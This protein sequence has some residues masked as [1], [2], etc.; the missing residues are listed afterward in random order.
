[1]IV[2]GARKNVN[3]LMITRRLALLVVILILA[4]LL[5]AHAQDE[6]RAVWQVTNFD[7]TVN[8]PGTERAL[9]ARA[10][11]SVRNVGRGSGS[12]LTLRISSKAE[13]KSVSVGGATASYRVTPETR[14]GAQRVT[15]ALLSAVAPNG[16]V[17]ATVDYRLPVEENSG[18]AALSPVGSQF[19]PLSLWYPSP[20]TSLAI[21]GADYAPFRLTVTGASAVSSGAEKS[22]NGNSVFEQT[23]HALPFFV[24]GSW[25]RVDG[26][27]NAKGIS[28][29]LPKGAGAD[30]RKQAERLI[31]LVAD[32]RTFG[33]G[34]FGAAPE[35]PLRLVAVSRGAGF[36]DAGTI[37]L[38]AGAFQRKKIDSITTLG[39]G[40]AV[41]HLW[42]GGATPVRGEGHG[43][44]REALA[45]FI[46]TQFIDQQFGTDAAEGERARQRLAY[47]SIAKRDAPLALMTPLDATYFNSIS[48]K[49]AMVWRLVDHVI[50]R[51]AFVTALRGLLLSG[52]S[53]PEGFNLARARA[54][55]AERGGPAA[56]GLLDAE[57]DHP[58][59]MDLMAGLPHQENGQWV[60]ALRN[61]GSNEVTVSVTATTDSGQQVT[62]LAT[63]PAHDFAQAVFKTASRVVR[64]EVDP[65]KLYPQLDYENDIAPRQVEI[66]GSLAEATRLFGAQ[67]FAKADALARNLIAAAPRMQEA[68][69]LF[70]RIL[71]AE[72]KTDEAEREF[73]KLADDR[74]PTPATLAWSAIGLGEIALRRGQATEAARD[75]NEAARADAEYSSTV[76]ARA[77]RIRAEVTAP[78]AIDESAKA[79]INQLDA[80]IRSGRQAEIAALIVPGEL[81]KFVRGAVGTQPE[82]WQTRVLRSEQLDA[83]HLALD[84]AL[85]TKQ[86][87]VEHSGT[88][89]YILARVGGSWKLNAIEYFEVR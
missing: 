29:F 7:I 84:V 62:L 47:E 65:E 34:L 13:I 73:R 87:G 41:A 80:A 51:D 68:R 43:V 57:F 35:V 77:A 32:A 1:M 3:H 86:L 71:L 30:E 24:V 78:P 28:A 2:P 23:L 88:A 55:F 39:I 40:E 11:V 26:S 22:A 20:N 53:D 18:V 17:A 10:I 38:G 6:P 76:A 60:A 37:L 63:I 72:N 33:A 66:S 31:A 9:N 50:G 45:R 16:T 4:A 58:T 15:I 14:G 64:V 8:N 46:A 75:F 25:D 19:L 12:S 36:D 21:H 48:N 79:F 67:E 70:A 54:V 42:I 56:K 85:N 61:L 59:D 89:V 83:N 44:V 27:G 74:L 82:S 49:G 52:Q 5:S 81:I 69:I